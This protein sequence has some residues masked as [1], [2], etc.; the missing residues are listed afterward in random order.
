MGVK[1]SSQQRKNDIEWRCTI[2]TT[3]YGGRR[4]KQKIDETFTIREEALLI[5]VDERLEGK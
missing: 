2:S 4:S 3:N 5:D 1:K